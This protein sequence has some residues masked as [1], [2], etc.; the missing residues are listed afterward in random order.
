MYLVYVH[1]AL[2]FLLRWCLRLFSRAFNHVTIVMII[3]VRCCIAEPRQRNAN[4]KYKCH[5]SLNT[6]RH[7]SYSA[8]FEYLVFIIVLHSVKIS[9]KERLF[10]LIEE[11]IFFWRC[12]KQI[13]IWSGNLN[14]FPFCISLPNLN[15]TRFYTLDYINAAETSFVDGS[16]PRLILNASLEKT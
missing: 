16:F 6:N 2:P 11:K 10:H 8:C 15:P 14:I 3:M 7:A 1:T 9:R 12:K 4:E 13:S 5:A